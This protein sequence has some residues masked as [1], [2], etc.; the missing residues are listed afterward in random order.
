MPRGTAPSHGAGPRRR[1]AVAPGRGR[2]VAFLEREGA[3]QHLATFAPR[4]FSP[5]ANGKGFAWMTAR[6]PVLAGR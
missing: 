5:G 4:R 2:S 6:H 3:P 1:Q